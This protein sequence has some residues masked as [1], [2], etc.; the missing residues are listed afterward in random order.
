MGSLGD[1][2]ELMHQARRLARIVDLT[3]EEHSVGRPTRTVWVR[4][5]GPDRLRADEH[6]GETNADHGDVAGDP[7]H[8]TL[9][10]ADG[11]WL[12]IRRNGITFAGRGEPPLAAGIP[13]TVV[14][15]HVLD[16][17]DLPLGLELAVTGNRVIA[18][19]LAITLHAERRAP[20]RE[21]GL[22]GLPGW[23]KQATGYELAIDAERGVLLQAGPPDRDAVAHL[24][25]TAALFDEP[26]DDNVFSIEPPSGAR[27]RR[28]RKRRYRRQLA[29]R[30]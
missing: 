29:G 15:G 13:S 10:V 8:S 27:V 4:K 18:G 14:I 9:V 7:V 11:R 20:G 23:G 17:S 5:N 24:V 12:A 19:R 28:M 2:L 21:T 6:I 22:T 1:A 30:A 16:P 3:F 25:V 26:P